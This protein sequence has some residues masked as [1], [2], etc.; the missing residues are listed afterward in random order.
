MTIYNQGLYYNYVYV[1]T[2]DP[3]Q[4]I[5]IVLALLVL[6]LCHIIILCC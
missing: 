6:L 1:K 3:V 5:I 2:L 4:A